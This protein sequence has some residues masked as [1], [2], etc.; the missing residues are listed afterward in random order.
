MPNK[1]IILSQEITDKYVVVNNAF[2]L[3]DIK[4]A[5][6]DTYKNESKDEIN[7]VIGDDKQPDKF[8]PQVKLERWSNEVNFSVRLV[9]NEV[10]EETVKTEADKIVWE[11]GNIKI[12][13]YDYQEGEGGYKFIWYLKSKPVSN[14]VEFTI[15]SKGLD[16][17]YQ[18]ELTPEEIAQGAVRPENVVGSY[19]VYHSTKGGMN[20]AYG[21]DYKVG[22]AF[23]IYRPHLIDANGLDAWGNLHIENGIYSV[24]IPQDFLDKAV[25]PIKSNDTFGYTS[26]GASDSSTIASAT[27]SSRMEGFA[28]SLGVDGTLN[29]ISTVLVGVS[30][31]RIVDTFVALY[32]EDSAG[33]GSHNL[34]AS[35]ETLNVSYTTTASFTT[36]TAAS[37]SLTSD[38][39]I[40]AH[41][42]N[43]EDLS[44]GS[45]VSRY[46]STSATGNRYDENTSAAGS[47]NTRKNE[48]PWTETAALQRSQSIY[49]TYTVSGGAVAQVHSNLLMMGF[50]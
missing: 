45:V 23:H 22:K 17:F 26:I 3:T 41:L 2:T 7:V 18:P 12:E 42:G 28:H 25:Y 13:N 6:L 14:K 47:Y 4:N 46:D 49:A 31:T 44:V 21:K 16:F 24:E 15:Q 8:Y 11:K 19:A 20:D 35:V 43:G 40:L 50:G 5:E 1:P 48:N 30:G 37:E 29:S 10:G 9:D 38:T 34:V 39:Y 32:R 33:A 36:F 27:N